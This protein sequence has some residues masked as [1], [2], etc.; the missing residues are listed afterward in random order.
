MRLFDFLKKNSKDVIVNAKFTVERNGTK[1]ESNNL[2]QI[3][4]TL[5]L[6]LI[7]FIIGIQIFFQYLNNSE[8][9]DKS[10]AKLQNANPFQT[11]FNLE[12]SDKFILKKINDYRQIYLKKEVSED[13]ELSA[14]AQQRADSMISEDYYGHKTLNGT[15]GVY[16]VN[17]D[18]AGENLYKIDIFGRFFDA[19]SAANAAVDGWNNSVGHHETMINSKFTRVGIGIASGDSPPCTYDTDIGKMV[20]D[21]SLTSYKRLIIVAIFCSPSPSSDFT[22]STLPSLIF[23][24]QQKIL[25]IPS[26]VVAGSC[27]GGAGTLCNSK[28]YNNCPS[29]MKPSCEIDGLHCSKSVQDCLGGIWCNSRC[30]DSCPPTLTSSCESDGVHC[31]D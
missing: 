30:Y 6:A 3:I 24:Q 26:N 13:E 21:S 28:C 18:A 14:V 17:C 9:S 23:T 5:L 15:R 25:D 29:D 4:P 27:D 31:R 7:L 11:G 8:L 20:C 1:N 2:M 10:V 12:S 22:P 16:M 19:E